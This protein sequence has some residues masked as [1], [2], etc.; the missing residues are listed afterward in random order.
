V[1]GGGVGLNSFHRTDCSGK[2]LEYCS[3]FKGRFWVECQSEGP[4][5]LKGESKSTG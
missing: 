3:L 4:D 1:Q 5:A 2:D